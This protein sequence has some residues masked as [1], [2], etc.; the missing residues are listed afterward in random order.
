MWC[1]GWIIRTVRKTATIADGQGAA[2]HPA[3]LLADSVAVLGRLQTEQNIK[4]GF[5]HGNVDSL[6]LAVHNHPHDSFLDISRLY[7]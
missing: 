2:G 5:R 4:S 1:I 6:E 7:L 3:H